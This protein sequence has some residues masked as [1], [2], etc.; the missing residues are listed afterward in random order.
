MWRKMDSKVENLAQIDPS[1]RILLLP[2]CL[3][4]SN[5]CIAKYNG[6][7][8]QCQECNPECAVNRLRTAAINYGYKGVCVAPGGRLAVKFVKESF[9][10]AV[11]A[12]ACQKELE[13][14]VHGVREL[15]GQDYKPLIVIIPLLKDGCVDTVVDTEKALKVLISGYHSS[16]DHPE[17][18]S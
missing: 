5:T 14:G 8:L 17:T 6:Q 10:E 13:E 1:K 15:T 2:H 12:V 9:P 4:Q 11:V 7:G 16:F 3:R 18:T